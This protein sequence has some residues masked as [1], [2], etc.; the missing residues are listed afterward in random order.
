MLNSPQASAAFD[1]LDN[2]RVRVPVN[3][4]DFKSSMG[5]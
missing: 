5:L 4:L 2:G 3:P 1:G